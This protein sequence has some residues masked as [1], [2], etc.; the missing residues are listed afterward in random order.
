MHC[1]VCVADSSKHTPAVAICRSCFIGLCISHFQ[2]HVRSGFESSLI[3]P[4]HHAAHLK[5]ARL[6]AGDAAAA[7]Q[8]P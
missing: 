5:K 2:T 3:G 7:A 8:L 4:C 1:F 6:A